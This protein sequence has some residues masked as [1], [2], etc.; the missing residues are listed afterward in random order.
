MIGSHH[1]QPR[2]REALAS[3]RSHILVDTL[4]NCPPHV[5]GEEPFLV[6]YFKFWSSA[7]Q[8]GRLDLGRLFEP[9]RSKRVPNVVGGGEDALVDID[10]SHLKGVNRK[11]RK[12]GKETLLRA[13]CV[14]NPIRVSISVEAPFVRPLTFTRLLFPVCEFI[15]SHPDTIEY[16]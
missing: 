16:V 3:S 4:G 15:S 6:R 13:K 8:F 7:L 9:E 2:T 1:R 14:W 10:T 5:Q 11:E 12:K